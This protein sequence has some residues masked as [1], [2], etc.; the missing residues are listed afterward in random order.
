[1]DAVTIYRQFVLPSGRELLQLDGIWMIKERYAQIG[2]ITHV[3]LST[4]RIYRIIDQCIRNRN[5]IPEAPFKCTC[6]YCSAS[7]LDTLYKKIYKTHTSDSI[8][9]EAFDELFHS[10]PRVP[11]KQPQSTQPKQPIQPT[12]PKQPQQPTQPYAIETFPFGKYKGKTFQEVFD[13]DKNYSFWCIES[14]AI[15]RSQGKPAS[16]AMANFVAYCKWKFT[17]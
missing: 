13:T 17:K 12:Q 16:P 8:L 6:G 9:D 3:Q 4:D 7:L 5:N 2:R 1:M 10:E 15:E 14:L 11:Q